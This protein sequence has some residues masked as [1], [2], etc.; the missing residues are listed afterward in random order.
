VKYS[1]AH[2]QKEPGTLLKGGKMAKAL[3]CPEQLFSM[4]LSNQNFV[5]TGGNSGIGL[6]T[7]TQLAKQ[8]ARVTLACRRISEGERVRAEILASGVR[9]TIEVLPLDLASLESV[10][11]FAKTFLERNERLNGLVNN[12]GVMNTPKGKTR[13]GFETQF[14]TNHL[15]HF[16]LTELLLGALK[17]GAP[18][19]V[20]NLSSCFHDKAMGREGKIDFDDL[21]FERKKY[22]GWEAYAQSKLANLLHAKQLAT[23]VKGEGVVAVSVHPGWVRTNLIGNSMPVWMQDFLLRP[24]L[25]LAGMLE[26]WEGAQSTLFALLSPEV[27]QNNGA[28]FSQ[29]GIYRTK[30][31]AKGGWPMKSPNPNAH[32]EE[33]ALRLEQVSRQLVGL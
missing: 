9:G 12:A 22:D 18:A 33:A 24:V 31:A 4:D 29:L 19:R 23:R 14:G 2:P 1:A 3:L 28:Y 21:H 6:I 15:G 26:P 8:G 20:V 11:A 27:P 17:K 5:V 10:R 16:L 13:D 25:R 32:S 30:E 7:V